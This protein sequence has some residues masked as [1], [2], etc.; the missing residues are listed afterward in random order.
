MLEDFV[1]RLTMRLVAAFACAVM[2]MPTIALAQ[3]Q[4]GSTGGT[5]GKTG[6]SSS[7]GEESPEAQPHQTRSVEKEGRAASTQSGT[8]VA[9][10]WRW[11]ANC[12]SGHYSGEFDLSQTTGGPFTGNFAGTNVSDL[13]AI[14]GGRANGGTI[15][16]TRHAPP[17]VNQHWSGRLTSGHISGSISGNESCSW[18]A[19]K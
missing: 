7:G 3:L 16:F 13:G 2:L 19:S 8:S 6:K 12:Q 10:R 9:G 11:S 15:S 4:P 18:Q 14:T 17:G 1:R 5:I